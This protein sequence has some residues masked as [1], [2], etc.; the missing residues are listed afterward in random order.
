MCV[1]RKVCGG[2]QDHDCTEHVCGR[3]LGMR[4]NEETGDLY[5]ADAYMGLLVVGPNGGLATKVATKAQGI[6][7]QFANALD[8]DRSS[9]LVYF[10]D[11][12]SLYPRR[13]T[14]SS[15]FFQRISFTII[16]FNISFF[17]FI[18]HEIILIHI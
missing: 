10:T 9:G 12:S 18:I 2:P 17:V 3:P 14:N 8:I 4:F 6:S 1:H 13:Y 5:I 15:Y 16:I 11:S 7:L